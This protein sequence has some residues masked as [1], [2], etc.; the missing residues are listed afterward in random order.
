MTT[1]GSTHTDI[2]IKG[3]LCPVELLVI[4]QLQHNVIIGLNV[5][6]D[7]N[8][9]I[10]IANSSLSLANDL[11]TVPLIHRYLP[12]NILR[13]INT[14]TVDP[15]H[16]V[17]L[18][19]RLSPKYNLG[20]SIIEHLSTKYS[21][22]MAVAK[23]FVEP[24]NRVTVCQVVNLT[25]KPFTLPART[26]IATISPAELLSHPANSHNGP[27]CQVNSVS[28][29][30][31]ASVMTFEDKLNH[32]TAVGFKLTPGDLAQEQFAELVDLLYNYRHVFAQDVKDLP[33]V[34]GVEYDL[35]LQPGTR[36]KR[37]RQYRYPP[38]MRQIIREQLSDWERAGIIEE[39]DAL[40]IHPLVLVKKRTV[41]G[42][43]NAPMK[44]RVCL[45]LRAIN[46][47]TVVESYPIPTFSN[48][49]ESFSDPPPALFSVLDAISGF[50][51][52]P[53]TEDSSK[54]LGL[55][56]DSKTYVMKRIPF[57]LTTSPFVYQKL[58]SKLLSGYQFIFACA[59]LDDCLV[60]S[61]DWSSHAQHLR[62][63]LDRIADSGLRL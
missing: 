51:Q 22:S 27:S 52:L 7:N 28:T 56:S 59:Y 62:L 12:R 50:L 53:L 31:D 19:V 11:Y 40:W 36:P 21:H 14:I 16:E 46:K 5:L 44:Y 3:Y 33:G 34:K 18:P 26:A 43:P 45:D 13:T 30:T 48:I 1:V 23:V 8:A 32:L 4:D 10:D 15:Y 24:A 60:W 39:G 49:V 42:D 25:N 35:R 57:G 2:S 61:N 55:E 63:V 37:Q 9:V 29:R 58:M 38:H 6:H 20:P 17:R 41:E 47:V 54:Y